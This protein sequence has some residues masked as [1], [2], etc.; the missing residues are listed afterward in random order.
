MKLA[1]LK[2]FLAAAFL[3]FCFADIQAQEKVE[4]VEVK[5]TG[6]MC[7][8]CASK[9]HKALKETAGIVDNEV[10]YPGDVAI[11]KYDPE[12][13]NPEAIVGVIEEKTDFTAEV[14]EES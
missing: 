11:V 9:V 6:M 8:G 12:K 13:T 7:G 2:P 3:V 1:I 4:T 5:V 10:K 14:K